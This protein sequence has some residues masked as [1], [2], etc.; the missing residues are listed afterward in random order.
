MI[1]HVAVFRWREGTTA[2]QVEALRAGLDRMPGAVPS[3][4]AYSH[5]PDLRLGEGRWDYGVV[6]DFDDSAGFQEYVDHP[7]HDA[8]RRELLAPLVADRG[9]VQIDL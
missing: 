5:G 1:R 6:A 2:E 7:E 9:H 8:V 4:R 3:V